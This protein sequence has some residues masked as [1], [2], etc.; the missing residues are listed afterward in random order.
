M[1]YVLCE[2]RILESSQG[3]NLTLLQ[4]KRFSPVE[5]LKFRANDWYGK[6]F[7]HGCFRTTIRS[8]QKL[9]GRVARTDAVEVMLRVMVRC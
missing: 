7:E 8:S 9:F 6:I 3:R 2:Q 5:L 4:A 1:Y